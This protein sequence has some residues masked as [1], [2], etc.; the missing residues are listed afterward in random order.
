MCSSFYWELPATTPSRQLRPAIRT[1][2]QTDSTRYPFPMKTASGLRLIHATMLEILHDITTR[3]DLCT[4]ANNQTA[5]Y[6]KGHT[7]IAGKPKTFFQC[8]SNQK[9][10]IKDALGGF[11]PLAAAT[12]S[13]L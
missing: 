10:I 6:L 2:S 9:Q 5:P 1:S 4:G 11:S 3:P 7:F 13:R 12:Y 8:Q